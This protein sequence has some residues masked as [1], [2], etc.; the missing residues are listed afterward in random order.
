VLQR[1]SP[2]I[3]AVSLVT[4]C[5]ARSAGSAGEDT[6]GAEDVANTE[7]NLES[8]GSSLV[9]SNGQSLTT[10]SFAGEGDL[11]V[12]SPT[13]VANPGF[14]FEP[15]GCLRIT[16]D[17]AQRHAS[18]VFGGCTGP[19]GL[20]ELTGTVTAD[21]TTTGAGQLQISYAAQGFKVNRSTIDTWQAT[22]IITASGNAREMTWN[23]MLTGTTAR[24]RTFHRTNQKDLKWTVGEPCLSVSGTS[25]GTVLG[26]DLATTITSYQRCADACPEAGSEI[27]VQNRRNGDS[28]D[29]QY[30]GGPRAKLTVNGKTAQIGLSCGD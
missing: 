29:I 20:L 11:H 7:S 22:A 23:A 10:A 5:V 1:L 19:L 21:W 28:I 4:A 18:Y 3:L 9:N 26:V 17:A 8:L 30:E 13:T 16:A 6:S 24:G 2:F 27:E 15:A 12:E 14:W 25:D